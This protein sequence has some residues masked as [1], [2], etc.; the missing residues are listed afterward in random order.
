MLENLVRNIS[1]ILWG[2]PF[3]C[4]LVLLG[5]YLT[6][7]LKVPQ[8]RSFKCLKSSI[9]VR[10]NDKK[11]SSFKALMSILAG[12]LGMGNITGVASAIITG[13]I[14]SIFWI[15]VS[16]IIAIPI[17]YA[18]N[19]LIVS[20]RKSKKHSFEGGTMYVLDELLGKRKLAVIF[21]ISM[22]LVSLSMGAMVQS[23]SLTKMLVNMTSANTYII[24]FIVVICSSYVI[25]GG[26]HRLTKINGVLIPICTIVYVLLCIVIIAVSP[27]TLIQAICYIVSTAFGIKPIAGA[28]IGITVIK[29]ITTGFCTGMFSNEAGMGSAPLM[30]LE[31]EENKSAQQIA[32]ALAGS[33]YIDTI[34]MCTLTGITLVSSGAYNIAD[35]IVML[36]TAFGKIKFGGYI[37]IF[38]MSVFAIATI[39]CWQYYG[40]C[41]IKYLVN[42]KTVYSLYKVIY[43]LFVFLGCV[44]NLNLVWDLANIFNVFMAIPNIYM[45]YA[46][47]Q[48]IKI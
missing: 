7:A 17:S 11:L 30:A 20:N 35:V 46:L 42:K 37:L 19:Y 15:F 45:I 48:E 40:E 44:L 38:C 32:Y 34:F 3:V 22:I 36:E 41:A 39:P 33:V 31:V 43:L 9:K 5:I 26:K 27:N 47:R 2:V 24:A 12:T 18:E 6:Y 28:I 14:G 1:E 16:G 10:K 29:S 25:F 23:N 8:I 4:I 21:S 13:G